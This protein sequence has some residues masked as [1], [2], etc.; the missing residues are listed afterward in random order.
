MSLNMDG[1]SPRTETKTPWYNDG[2]FNIVVRL[3]AEDYHD[4]KDFIKINGCIQA[5]VLRTAI[6]EFLTSRGYKKTTVPAEKLKEEFIKLY[7]EE[8]ER[9]EKEIK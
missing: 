3:N 2:K 8:I 7:E 4:I 6:R 9:K 1:D 5:K